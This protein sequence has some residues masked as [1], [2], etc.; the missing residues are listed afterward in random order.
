[1]SNILENSWQISFI[2]AITHLQLCTY[3]NGHLLGAPCENVLHGLDP[4]LD[5]ASC[6]FSFLKYFLAYSGPPNILPFASTAHISHPNPFLAY[7]RLTTSVY[8]N[9]KSALHHIHTDTHITITSIL[10]FILFFTL[11]PLLLAG[12]LPP[13]LP[14]GHNYCICT[15]CIQ[16]L[17]AFKCR[18]SFPLISYM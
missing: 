3:L 11:L 15:L 8:V 10:L 6:W 17:I 4:G 18:R 9:N 13:T 14:V 2:W 5:C 12:W 1:M 16:K 7:W